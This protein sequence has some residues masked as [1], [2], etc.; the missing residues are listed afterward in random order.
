MKSGYSSPNGVNIPFSLS[1]ERE[2]VVNP[3]IS[4]NSDSIDF[5]GDGIISGQIQTSG[6]GTKGLIRLIYRSAVNNG[7]ADGE[8][9][10]R[11]TTGNN[12]IYSFTGINETYTYDVIA[13]NDGWHD[14]VLS[15]VKPFSGMKPPIVNVAWD[16]ATKV[17]NISWFASGLPEAIKLYRNYGSPPDLSLAPLIELPGTATS[18]VDTGLRVDQDVYYVVVSVKQ[19]LSLESNAVMIHSGFLPKGMLLSVHAGTGGKEYNHTQ[20]TE[21]TWNEW[22]SQTIDIGLFV[23]T[24]RDCWSTRTAPDKTLE[25]FTPTDEWYIGCLCG[26]YSYDEASMDVEFLDESNQVIAAIRTRRD[27]SRLYSLNMFYGSSLSNLTMATTYGSYPSGY[28][29]LKFSDTGMEWTPDKLHGHGKAY[30]QNPWSFNADF[31]S[32]TKIKFSNCLAVSNYNGPAA[33]YVT[34]RRL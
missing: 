31:S 2:D 27:K 34:I 5:Q 29:Y 26:S 8:E 7:Y 6:V 4:Y 15:K 25:L 28:G 13:S 33:A 14:R 17:A 20:T 32:V 1:G 16:D 21:P 10:K 3:V 24:N 19:T 12:G 30:G 9:V 23:A 11:I 22:F 18:Y